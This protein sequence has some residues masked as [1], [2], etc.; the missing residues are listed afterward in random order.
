MMNDDP[1]PALNPYNCP[2]KLNSISR[3]PV[4]AIAATLLISL[5]VSCASEVPDVYLQSHLYGR[6][7]VSA[8]IDTTADYS[9]ILLLVTDGTREVTDT[10]VYA[11]TRRDGSFEA[12]A[13]F[14]ERGQ[15]PLQ[16]KR[17]G[18]LI[19]ASY[20]ILAPG[21]SV[22][23][24]AELP[25]FTRTRKISSREHDAFNVYERLQR[26]YA[27]I[28]TFVNNG[29]LPQDTIPYVLNTWSDLFWSVRDLHEG[30][31]AAEYAS[32]TAIELLFGWNDDRMMEYI[33]QALDPDLETFTTMVVYGA[34][35]IARK[36]GL[37]SAVSYL[38]S[39]TAVATDR[40]DEVALQIRKIELL[41]DSAGTTQ[42]LSALQNL[43]AKYSDQ[44]GISEWASNRITD[45]E[46]FAPGKPM[47]DFTLFSDEGLSISS[48]MLM[49]N[50]YLL[51]IVELADPRY[52]GDYPL[53]KYTNSNYASRGLQII[54]IPV[55]DDP[56]LKDAFYEER[57]RSWTIADD[58]RNLNEE[59]FGSLNI[60]AVPTRFL[61]DNNGRIVRKYVDRDISLVLMDV[62]ELFN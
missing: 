33:A 24:E 14:R 8:E 57:Q 43:S 4:F 17:Y 3:S 20:V 52:Q 32:L 2:M 5:I 13:R 30:T 26:N 28:A 11:E 18:N 19:S 60:S 1:S 39:L 41:G 31:L 6:I 61:V 49:G 21:D 29:T 40:Q 12:T 27:R 37:H 58:T 15:Y 25:E 54:T 55:D 44:A 35:G 36:N 53:I 7:S 16:I 9:G 48:S 34:D 50:A 46:R 45:L 56:V 42:A 22:R 10:L 38:D 23:L 47:P 59:L 62:D 51:E